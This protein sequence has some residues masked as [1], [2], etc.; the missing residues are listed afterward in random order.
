MDI[1]LRF[2]FWLAVKTEYQNDG[3]NEAFSREAHGS[4]EDAPALT[5]PSVPGRGNVA[6]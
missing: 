4:F 5:L 2:R 3:E 1:R 6:S